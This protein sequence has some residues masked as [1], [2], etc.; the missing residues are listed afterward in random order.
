M[1]GHGAPHD[2]DDRAA[3]PRRGR[4]LPGRAGARRR[5]AGLPKGRDSGEQRDIH[6]RNLKVLSAE[7]ASPRLG[8]AQAAGQARGD[9]QDAH[10]RCSPWGCRS[11]AG[12]AQAA[13]ELSV[14]ERLQDRRYGVAGERARLIGF[15]DGRFY[16]NGWHI[17]GEMG[18]LWTEPL[19]LVD[20]VW[21]GI[22]GEWVGPATRFT[23]G[24]GYAK[25]DLPSAGGLTLERTDFAPDGRRA[26]LFGLKLTNPGASARTVT[27]KVDAHSELMTEYP[28]G[29][30]G[31]HAQRGRQPAGHGAV[32]RAGGALVFRDQGKLPHPNA[33]VHD[34]AA[35]VASTMKPVAG[36]TGRSSER[37]PRA[38]GANVCTAEEPPSACD[39]GP[40]GKGKGGQLRYEVTLRAGASKTLWVAAAGSDKGRAAVGARAPGRPARSGR[41]ARGKGRRARALGPLHPALAARRPAARGGRR[42][43][44][45]EHPRPHP[46]RRGHADPLD[47]PGQAVP[48]ARGVRRARP[49][50]GR[51]L[52][53]LPVDVRH[54][55]RVHRV[56]QRRGR[57]V[58]G[59]RGPPDRP[60]RH[61][62][63]AQRPLRGRDHEVVSDGDRFGKLRRTERAS[64]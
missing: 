59:D 53:R 19:K 22:D 6:A 25:F 54:R 17:T 36:E 28:V 21:F 32:R 57:A 33:P 55:R 48:A 41:A 56:R 11:R 34:Y 35:M 29:L 8:P 27:V 46:S 18:G 50:G 15:E 16:A 60:A 12:A 24:W 30:H 20:G 31:R 64:Q 61:L 23:S 45:A 14:S 37:V 4:R 9:A 58:R 10:R 2:R 40:F 43:G 38:A 51:R 7:L 52:P 62:G 47:R 42:L 3:H 44:Q 26:A 63:H 13:P 1:P 5:E 39:D 49:L